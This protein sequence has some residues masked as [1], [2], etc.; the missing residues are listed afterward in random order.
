[1]FILNPI[2]CRM[3]LSKAILFDLRHKWTFHFKH[4]Q[5]LCPEHFSLLHRVPLTAEIN[6][7]QWTDPS[8]CISFVILDETSR[9]FFV[10]GS[11]SSSLSLSSDTELTE[12]IGNCRSFGF[13]NKHFAISDLKWN[14]L[15]GPWLVTS[16]SSLP[17]REFIIIQ[18]L[19]T[20]KSKIL[21]IILVYQPFDVNGIGCKATN[22]SSMYLHLP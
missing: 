22:L 21:Y 2:I 10:C 7:G 1:M 6:T 18:E 13:L 20:I 8:Y 4:F 17:R 12:A 15:K 14:N 5:Y 9:A 16:R 19:I 3:I 11:F